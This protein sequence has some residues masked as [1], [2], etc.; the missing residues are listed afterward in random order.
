MDPAAGKG[1]EKGALGLCGNVVIG[2]A[3]TAPA[4]AVKLRAFFRGETLTAETRPGPDTGEPPGRQP[5]GGLCGGI[6]GA[7]GRPGADSVPVTG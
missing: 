1:W 6:D 5:V 4:C 7:L 2:L 3:S